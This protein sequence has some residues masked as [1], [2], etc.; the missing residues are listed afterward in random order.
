M[1]VT[2]CLVKKSIIHQWCWFLSLCLW[3]VLWCLWF[4]CQ[5]QEDKLPVMSC[6][7]VNQ[8]SCLVVIDNRDLIQQDGLKTQD[9]RMMKKC[10]T[11]LC[12]P[13]LA[14]HFF[15]HS[16]IPSLPVV[17]LHKVPCDYLVVYLFVCFPLEYAQ[18]QQYF[19][20]WLPHAR[21]RCWCCAGNGF[22]FSW[23][24]GVLQNWWL[25]VTIII[26]K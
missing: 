23:W 22:H 21:G 3:S 24:L 4:I 19:H 6:M 9:S 14:Q 16:A 26:I 12:I 10:I 11:R 20:L 18:V 5:C 1:E 7:V 25:T 2:S 15:H 8:T 17:L 13:G